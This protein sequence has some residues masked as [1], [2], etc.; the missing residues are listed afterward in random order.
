MVLEKN[1][2]SGMDRKEIEKKVPGENNPPGW[3]IVQR[4]LGGE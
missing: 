3:E 2:P 1:A 4:P